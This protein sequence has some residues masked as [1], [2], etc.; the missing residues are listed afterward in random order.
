MTNQNRV[1]FSI[2]GTFIKPK[3][4]KFLEKPPIVKKNAMAIAVEKQFTRNKNRN[5]FEFESR[6][7]SIKKF[8]A[9]AKKKTIGY[10]KVCQFHKI[11]S[12][13]TTDRIARSKDSVAM[14]KSKVMAPH[15]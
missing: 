2:M 6:V 12:S 4:R 9:G 5:H 10:R 11:P 1:A 7:S 3:S 13:L 15:M 14:D 8:K